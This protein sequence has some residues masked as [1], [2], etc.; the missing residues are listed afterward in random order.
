[1]LRSLAVPRATLS[2]FEIPATDP[3]RLARFFREVFGW[4]HGEVPWDGPRY[5]RLFAPEDER[6]PGGGIL[7]RGN[8][9]EALVD[10]LTVMVDIEGEPLDAVLARVAAHGGTVLARPT[11][12]GGFGSYARFLDPEGNSFG[13]WQ[14]IP[15]V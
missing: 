3:D 8:G 15:E 7:A 9:G 11:P 4:E 10:R 1:M 14:K 6:R 13:L 12:I 5:L 2:F